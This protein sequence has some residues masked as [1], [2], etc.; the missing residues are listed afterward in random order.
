MKISTKI[1]IAAQFYIALGYIALFTSLC[2]LNTTATY[3]TEQDVVSKWNN[4]LLLF[5]PFL[6]IYIFSLKTT[7][8]LIASNKPKIEFLSNQE[9]YFLLLTTFIIVLLGYINII[10]SGNIP[11]LS[12]GYISRFDYLQGTKLWFY[13]KI[14]GAAFIIVP[15]TLGFVSLHNHIRKRKYFLILTNAT[16]ILYILYLILIGQ[17]FGGITAGL[18]YFFFPRIVHSCLTKNIKIKFKHFA[19]ALICV[20]TIFS[21]IAYHYAKLPVADE[22][23][24]PFSFI[25]YRLLALQGHTFWGAA[26]KPELFPIHLW[27][28]GMPNMMKLLGPSGIEDDIARGVRFTAGYQGILLLIFPNFIAYIIHAL[29]CLFF[30]FFVAFWIVNIYKIEYLILAYV[31]VY[32]VSFFSHGSLMYLAG[33]KTLFLILLFIC[34]AFILRRGAISRLHM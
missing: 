4:S 7:S 26:S 9:L 15:I 34:L 22:F 16:F 33:P 19:Y 6:L 18:Y 17:K 24:G 13:L 29:L 20:I 32:L 23:G 31:N 10:I 1:A 14:F 27:W 3:I 30:S 25:F 5:I 11:F 28:D 21:L 2:Y 12:A 8:L